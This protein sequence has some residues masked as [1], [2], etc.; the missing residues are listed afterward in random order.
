MRNMIRSFLR[1]RGYDV[2]S[3]DPVNHPVARRQKLMEQHR[4]DLV[5]DV[6]ANTGQYAMHLRNIGYHG[7]IVSFEPLSSAYKALES[8]SKNDPLWDTVNIALGNQEGTAIINIAN[9]SQSSSILDMLPDHVRAAP[10]SAYVGKEEIVIRTMDSIFNDYRKPSNNVYLKIDA[11][12][13]ERNI[14]EGAGRSLENILGIQLEVSLVP[15]YAGETLFAEMIEFMSEKGY[16][17]MS[18]EPTYGNSDTGQLLQADCV[19]FR[20]SSN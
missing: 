16:V 10:E 5:F 3:Y 6:G 4:I 19:F 13:F 11:Q 1:N 9:N 7:K 20:P 15:L 12:G 18:I 2:V 17:L 14:V 8:N